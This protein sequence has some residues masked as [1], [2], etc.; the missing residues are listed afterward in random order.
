MAALD[1]VRDTVE[2]ANNAKYLVI[3]VKGGVTIYQGALVAVD[4]NG[5]AIPGKKAAGITAAGRAEETADNAGGA[6]GAISIKVSRGVFVWDNTATSANKVGAAHILKPCYIEDD[7]TV[8]A[9]ATGASIAGL[10]IDVDEGGVV[11]E[12]N[13]ALTAPAA[14]A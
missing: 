9:L 2:V 3:P 14:G 4:A 6:D 11:V 7:Q 8:T 12:I 5:Y 13:P 1:N 10:V